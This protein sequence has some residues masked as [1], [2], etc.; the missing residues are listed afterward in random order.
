[1]ANFNKNILNEIAQELD[2]GNNCYFN[3]KTEEIIAIP[4]SS[5]VLDDDMFQE[6]YQADL[7]KVEKHKADYIKLEVL[8]SFESFKIMEK[9]VAQI[10][11]Q[12]FKLELENALQKRKPFQNFRY[13]I[14]QSDY[15]QAWFDFKQ[16]ELEKRVEMELNNALQS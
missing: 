8:E 2:C 1:M 4:N 14:D 11:N 7:N 6:F 9:F 16:N 10:P 15:R 5:M 13:S 12:S 3:F